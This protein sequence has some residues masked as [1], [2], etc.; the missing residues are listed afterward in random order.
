M[1]EGGG[2]MILGGRDMFFHAIERAAREWQWARLDRI[3]WAY[4]LAKNYHRSQKRKGGDRYFEHCRAV[5][6]LL[7][8]FGPARGEEIIMGLLHDA[9]E[10]QFVP[11]GMFQQLFGDAVDE[12]L[13]LLSHQELEYGVRGSIRKIAT[14]VDVY[15]SRLRLGSHGVRRVKIV[16][17][18]HNFTTISVF[19][20]DKRIAKIE[21]TRR[22]VYP[23]AQATD[24]RMYIQLQSLVA[25]CEATL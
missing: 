2:P 9:Y 17:R 3:E 11:R 14:P 15:Y 20:R 8:E 16:D 22:Y 23:L 4:S 18:I 21:E 25:Q 6:L 5:A 24:D 10:D 7:I 19:P 1:A 12:G 13:A